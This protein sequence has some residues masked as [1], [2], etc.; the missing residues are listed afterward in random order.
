VFDPGRTLPWNELTRHAT[1]EPLGVK[2]FAA[3]LQ[4]K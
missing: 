4:D 2:S 3:D 1:G